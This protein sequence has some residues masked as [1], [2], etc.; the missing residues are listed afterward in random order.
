MTQE[1]KVILT[2]EVDVNFPVDA[3]KHY[4]KCM[5]NI[6]VEGEL[7]ADFISIEVKEEA[8]IYKNE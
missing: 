1:I 3:L 6:H 7:I 4:F 8:E 5:S 2:L